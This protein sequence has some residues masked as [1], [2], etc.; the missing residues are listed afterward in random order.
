MGQ[1]GGSEGDGKQAKGVS[2][3]AE[4][5]GGDRGEQEEGQREHEAA[6]GSCP[7]SQDPLDDGEEYHDCLRA[8]GEDEYRDCE[9][10]LEEAMDPFSDVQG[11]ELSREG[12]QQHGGRQLA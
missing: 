9:S 5:Q 2:G 10:D 7:L 3:G 12:E 1:E 11:W 4:V 6:V 8:E